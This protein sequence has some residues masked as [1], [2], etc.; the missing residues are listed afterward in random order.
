MSLRLPLEPHLDHLKQQAKDLQRRLR[1]LRGAPVPLHE[2]QRDLAREYGEPSWPALVRRVLRL[3]ELARHVRS[4]QGTHGNAFPAVR[5]AG[6]VSPQLLAEAALSHP[7][8]D[9]RFNSINLIDHLGYGDECHEALVRALRDPVPRVRRIA[10]HALS[11]AF[12]SSKARGDEGTCAVTSP[13][14]TEE[15]MRLAREDANERV[16]IAATGR[17]GD[18]RARRAEALVEGIAR[19]GSVGEELRRVAGAALVAIRG[20]A[21]GSADRG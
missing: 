9:V 7:H 20:E 8:P 16:R 4:F 1:E 12:C 13:D 3:S 14:E 10:V 19:D 15:L 18:V 6:L 17:L 2:V 11:C 5:A 21:S